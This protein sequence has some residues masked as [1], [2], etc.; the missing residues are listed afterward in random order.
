MRAGE[1]VVMS[2]SG[3]LGET[4]LSTLPQKGLRLDKETS[5]SRVFP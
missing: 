2:S 4:T 1:A 5:E 3:L